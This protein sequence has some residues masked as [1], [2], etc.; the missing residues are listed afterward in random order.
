M[1]LD[2]LIYLC[3]TEIHDNNTQ[4]ECSGATEENHFLVTI[5][6]DLEHELRLDIDKSILFQGFLLSVL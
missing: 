2:F 5:S 4:M 1:V 3:H 6:R